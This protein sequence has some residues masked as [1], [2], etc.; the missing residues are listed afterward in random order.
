VR[1]VVPWLK[2][3]GVATTAAAILDLVRLNATLLKEDKV[4]PSRP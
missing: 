1:T 4:D 3:C 2:F